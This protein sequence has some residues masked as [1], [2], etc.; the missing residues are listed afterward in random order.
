MLEKKVCL[1]GA[2][3]VGK[4][5]LVQ[6]FVSGMFSESY[7]TTIGVTI[8]KKIVETAQETVS[9][10]IWDIYG[11]DEFQKVRQSYLRGASGYLVVVDATRRATLTTACELYRLTQETQGSYPCI[12]ILNKSDL[13]DQ[14]EIHETDLAP[15]Q[16][17]GWTIKICSAKTGDGVEEAFSSLTESMLAES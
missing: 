7:H 12:M 14:W 11:E 8:Q 5:S 4:T 3:A 15:L 6:Q 17:E 2:F 1:L 16:Q 9:L 13:R 10:I